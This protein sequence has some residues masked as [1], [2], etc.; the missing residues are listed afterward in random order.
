MQPR[1]ER[2]ICIRRASRGRLLR[3]LSWREVREIVGFEMVI[4]AG[5]EGAILSRDR[6]EA[7]GQLLV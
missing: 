4:G 6:G 2:S 7:E 1:E 5:C 3:L